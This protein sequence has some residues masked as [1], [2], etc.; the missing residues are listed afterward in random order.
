[1][2]II[3]ILPAALAAITLAGVAGSSARAASA[4]ELGDHVT[5]A[6][7]SPNGKDVFVRIVKVPRAPSA[8]ARRDRPMM[9]PAP[10]AGRQRVNSLAQG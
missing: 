7:R 4:A 10:C 3:T 6:V 8:S 5:R 9:D 2:K 1:M